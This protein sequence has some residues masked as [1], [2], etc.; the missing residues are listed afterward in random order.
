MTIAEP[1]CALAM[2]RGRGLGVVLPDPGALLGLVG[3][4]PVAV[5]GV[6]GLRIVAS[7]AAAGAELHAGGVLV[8]ERLVACEGRWGGGVVGVGEQGAERH[9]VFD[10]LIGALPDM[11]Q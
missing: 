9:A 3:Q 1:A 5:L 10:G 2:R 7:A 8:A 4:L 6:A 11:R